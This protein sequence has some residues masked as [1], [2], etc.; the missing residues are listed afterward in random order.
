[1]DERRSEDRFTVSL[2]AVW[3]GGGSRPARIT[4]LSEGGCF[5]DA[6]GEAY[7]GEPLMLR[8]KLPDGT[9][10]ELNGE[11]A[12]QMQPVGFGVRFVNLSDEQCEQLRSFIAY[13]RG[14]HDPVTAILR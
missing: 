14:P 3:D 6:I 9:W 4:D 12:H 13:L 8:V 11:I 1:M 2:G 5:V 7:I 10:L